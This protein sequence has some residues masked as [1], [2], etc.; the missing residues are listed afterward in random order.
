MLISNPPRAEATKRRVRRGTAI[1]SIAVAAVMVALVTSIVLRSEGHQT[2][3]P[4]SASAVSGASLPGPPEAQ[5]TL[6]SG[7]APVTV[8]RSF[9]GISTEYWTIPVWGNTCSC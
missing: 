1:V 9:L 8:P 4:V 2:S 6:A 3:A 5:V 7:V